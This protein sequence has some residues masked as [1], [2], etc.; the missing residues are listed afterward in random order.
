MVQ[1]FLVLRQETER[2]VILLF[3]NV[4]DHYLGRKARKLQI[5]CYYY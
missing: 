2:Y 4:S 3:T 1:D 5:K